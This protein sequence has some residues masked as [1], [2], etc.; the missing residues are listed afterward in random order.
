MHARGCGCECE[1]DESG[2]ESGE[3]HESDEI[4]AGVHARALFAKYGPSKALA[5]IRQDLVILLDLQK[6]VPQKEYQLEVM[7]AHKAGL[8]KEFASRN[9]PVP[10]LHNVTPDRSVCICDVVECVS[11]E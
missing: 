9:I 11:V 6:Y 2:R 7:K 4:R 1:C 3:D 5:E 8:L 10:S